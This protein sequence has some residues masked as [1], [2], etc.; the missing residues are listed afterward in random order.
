MNRRSVVRALSQLSDARDRFI[1]EETALGT[2][3][4][5]IVRAWRWTL[6]RAFRLEKAMEEAAIASGGDAQVL[7]MMLGVEVEE[8]ASPPERGSGETPTTGERA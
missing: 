5:D 7:A 4:E 8:F 1:D 2:P 3:A 6:K